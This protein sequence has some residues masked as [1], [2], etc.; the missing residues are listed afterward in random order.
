MRPVENKFSKNDITDENKLEKESS[1]KS[2]GRR[3]PKN[4]FKNEAFIFLM[5]A[6]PPA[7]MGHYLIYVFLPGVMLMSIK[8][9][10][11]A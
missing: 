8:T 6:N 4:L 1:L 3:S 2:S 9:L 11:L 10:Y 5:L 7:V